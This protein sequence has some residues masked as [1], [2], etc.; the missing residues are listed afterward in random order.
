MDCATL[1]TSSSLLEDALMSFYSIISHFTCTK[2]SFSVSKSILEHHDTVDVSF[3]LPKI[4]E[5]SDKDWIGVYC[6]DPHEKLLP[7][8]A[9]IDWKWTMEATLNGRGTITF[10][11]F[12]NMRC[13]WQFRLFIYQPNW[14]GTGGRYLK[15]GVSEI[16]HMKKGPQ[17]PVQVHLALGNQPQE[18]RVM[19]TSA[20]VSS[21]RVWYGSAPDQLVYSS[22]AT[23]TT[24][25][26]KDMCHRPAILEGARK[27]RS[28]GLLHDALL[29]DLV[30]GKRYYYQVGNDDKETNTKSRVFTFQVPPEPGTSDPFSFFVYGD[31]GDW[32]IQAVGEAPPYRTRGTAELMREDMNSGEYNYIATMHDGDLAYGLGKTYLWDQFG[33]IV[34]PVAAEL[35]YMVAVGNHEYCHTSGGDKDPSGAPGNG[36]HPIWGN[37]GDD[38][39]GE[40]GVPTSKRFHM[41]ENGNQM[42]WYSVEMGLVHHTVISS[43][44]DY[45]PGSQMYQWLEKDFAKVNRSIT[46]WLILH[47]HR[48]MYCSENYY[49]DYKV[50]LYI[51]KYLE[52]LLGKYK[53]DVV[54][55]G[56]YHAYERT[57][58]VYQDKCRVSSKTNK[59]QAPVY[60]MV[61]SAGA[62]ID[63]TEYYNVSWRAA[64]QMEY[65][66]GRMHIF[67]V[68]HGLFEFK[69]NKD[70]IIADSQWIITDHEWNV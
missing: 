12:V 2:S 32:N 65:G 28:P 47:M 5:N 6:L 31:M 34:E 9:Y 44:H 3:S 37:Y 17:E 45:T 49:S 27:F 51:R 58:P 38:S 35:A 41:P 33:S 62:D 70:Q 13:A 56:H 26:A 14:F 52:P 50:S 15:M 20:N 59:A 10:G 16:I 29:M 69:R 22:I 64:A 48:P 25:H 54:F 66:Y 18:M 1:F 53:V 67:N 21:P 57:C 39:Q 40:C 63:H 46:P 11:P 30:P 55:S 60:I 36:F 43:E 8:E 61:G 24:Y 7:D 19:W 42:F 68:T 4:Q 23:S